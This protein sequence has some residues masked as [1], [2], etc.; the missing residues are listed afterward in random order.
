M[1]QL[2]PRSYTVWRLTEL[3]TV[4]G[5]LQLKVMALGPVYMLLPVFLITRWATA[6]SLALR[7]QH[8]RYLFLEPFLNCLYLPFLTLHSHPGWSWSLCMTFHGTYHIILKSLKGLIFFPHW[9]WVLG[10]KANF[11]LWCLIQCL[12]AGQK[13]SI[14]KKIKYW[15]DEGIQH[16]ISIDWM[17]TLFK[18]LWIWALDFARSCCRN[19]QPRKSQWLTTSVFLIHIT[20]EGLQ[21]GYGSHPFCFS[22]YDWRRR[23]SLYPDLTFSWQRTILSELVENSNGS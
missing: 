22:F 19:K 10:G 3:L 2:L 6:T 21:V 5:L 23:N 8:S 4:R 1:S 18:Q 12:E 14:E 16:K 13:L 11:Y 17:S 20:C 15:M 9:T 7:T